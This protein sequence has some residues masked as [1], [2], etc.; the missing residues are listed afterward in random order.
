MLPA[1]FRAVRPNSLLLSRRSP[2]LHQQIR[3]AT[4]AASGRANKAKDGPGKRLGAKKTQGEK[5]RTGMIIYRQRGTLWFPGENAGMG[6]DHTIFAMAPGFVRYYRDPAKHP[7]RKYIG[8]ALTPE[9]KLP[10]PLNAARVRRLGRVE[11]PLTEPEPMPKLGVKLK[12]S[13]LTIGSD[14]RITMANWKIG[15]SMRRVKV[16]MNNPWKRWR[17]KNAR[18]FRWRERKG[19]VPA[20]ELAKKRPPHLRKD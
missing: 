11:V 1:L 12:K 2:A 20:D 16:R 17:L 15:R 8:I 18:N 7:K 19:M 6:R 10:H 5:V 4:H 14:Y 3:E 9:Q 13:D